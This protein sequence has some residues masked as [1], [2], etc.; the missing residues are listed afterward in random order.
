MVILFGVVLN[1]V[2][3]IL[4][5]CQLRKIWWSPIIM[6]IIQIPW[7]CYF[8]ILGV[9]AY[10]MIINTVVVLIINICCIKKLYN[11]R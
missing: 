4:I 7:I 6:S 11:E 2:T 3:C 1:V 5:F 9:G 8:L 10:P